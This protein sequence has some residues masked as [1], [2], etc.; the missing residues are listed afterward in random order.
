[1]NQ[2]AEC[3]S[4][5]VTA[6]W[7][8][9]VGTSTKLTGPTGGSWSAARNALTWS[10]KRVPV[11]DEAPASS[12]E[13][14]DSW[15]A[16]EIARHGRAHLTAFA[17]QFRSDP[18]VFG[19]TETIIGA[20]SGFVDTLEAIAQRGSSAIGTIEG[21]TP[22]ERAESFLTAF[23]SGTVGDGGLIAEAAARRAALRCGEYLLARQPRLASAV[24]VGGGADADA[25]SGF[26]AELFC[27][28]YGLF[29]A[30]TV[31]ELMTAVIAAKITV[32]VPVFP[33][34]DPAGDLAQ[35]IAERV[36]ENLPT[37]CSERA[38]TW[39][40]DQDESVFDVGRKLLPTALSR[41]L[42]FALTDGVM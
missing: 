31:K 27:M 35:W 22:T 14:P 16:D 38:W 24:E 32:A 3:R 18:A 23:V 37:P 42:A 6:A 33:V 28:L 41:A 13:N 11:G 25:G 1:M 19:L 36:A 30:E 8:G 7:G 4:V 9:A 21:R 15:N 20:G 34:F 10:L 40:G 29:F 17:Q 12:S 26:D 2:H 5:E 39:R